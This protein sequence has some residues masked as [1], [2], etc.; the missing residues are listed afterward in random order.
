[1]D[2]RRQARKK[3]LSLIIVLID[4]FLLQACGTTTHYNVLPANLESQVEIPGFQ[5]VRA[6]GDLPSKALEQSAVDSLHQEKAA[7]HG[8]LLPVA[9]ALA[10]SGGGSDGAFGAGFLCGWSAAGTRPSFKLVTGIST[11]ALMAP[12]A[13]LGPSYDERLKKV[14]TTISDEKIYTQYSIFTNLLSI[15][16]ISPL[17]SLA[18]N[19][20][21]VKLVNEIVDEEMLRKIAAEHRKGRRLLIG[22]TQF[23]AQ[24]MVIWNMGEIAASRS[25][26]ALTLFR[27]IL[28]A[29]SALPASFPPQF[30]KVKAAGKNYEEM[31]VD[32]GL[33]VQVML[34]ESALIPFSKAQGIRGSVNRPRTLYI[35]R[36][37][38][39]YADW[40][41][42]EPKTI[43]IALRAISSLT[44]SQGVGDLYRLYTYAQRDHMDYN[45]T[46]VPKEFTEK[47]KT[48]FDQVY[49]R[50]LFDLGYKMGRSNSSWHKYPPGFVPA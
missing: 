35:I 29:S 30:F 8:Q 20:P 24:R 5:D 37:E 36:N 16:N 45:L 49:M 1:M 50:N 47:A 34:Y 12:F 22:T 44:K 17:P 28:L 3:Y 43:N 42:V 7:N 2:I 40:E 23:D 10:L 32:G 6:W 25:P 26:Q 46:F 27:K 19:A 31:H 48:P 11:G 13:F 33:E 41:Y 21:L 39:I 18:S 14:Y 9:S 38:R 15:A 4:S